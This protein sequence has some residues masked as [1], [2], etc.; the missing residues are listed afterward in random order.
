MEYVIKRD[1]RK[2]PFD[3]VRIYNAI[4]AAMKHVDH[5]NDILAFKI[6][7]DI[8]RMA[9]PMSV[10]QI[11]DLVEQRL[12]E[13]DYKDVAKAYI[14]YRAGKSKIRSE[15]MEFDRI[16]GE[17]LRAD[18]VQNQNANVD[19]ASFGGRKGEADSEM[20]RRYALNNIVSDMARKNHESNM[21]YI[22]DLDS[23]AVGMHNCLTLPFDDLLANGFNTRQT[24]VRPANS[25]STAFQLI[26][27]LFQLQS[28]QQFGGVSASHLDWSM[29]PYV[30]KSFIKHYNDGLKY[31]EGL[32]P[33]S[34]DTAKRLLNVT[35]E[36]EHYKQHAKVWQ[37]AMD[38]T[39]D[40]IEQAV[41]GMFHNL[42][43]GHSN[44][45]IAVNLA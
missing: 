3:R 42:K 28:L 18:N 22:H 38:K 7:I 6:A 8:E 13:S 2:A 16:I 33:V 39:K 19:E 25:V 9:E 17:K 31:I 41:E 44:S 36:H 35:I 12:M 21:I 29:V 26:A 32:Q 37:Y 15:Q 24:D 30:R 23:Y 11:Q 4:K 34:K 5:E 27:V 14:I 45:N 40:E 10:E 20:M 1:G 43:F